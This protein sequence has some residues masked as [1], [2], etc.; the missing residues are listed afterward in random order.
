[1][2]ENDIIKHL[3][4]D[5]TLMGLLAGNI[6]NKYKFHLIQADPDVVPPFVV[7]EVYTD[8]I[9]FE[10]I[11]E[12]DIFKFNIFAINNI[13]CKI[14]ADRLKKLLSISD[15]LNLSSTTEISSNEY[16]IYSGLHIGSDNYI[17]DTETKIYILPMN[18]E[19]VYK[20]KVV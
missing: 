7:W 9:G 20:R 10:S 15:E 1:M 3:T 5:A 17:K 8:L 14:I 6:T 11:I 16:Y 12:T 19:F 2:I 4:S 13:T 18:F